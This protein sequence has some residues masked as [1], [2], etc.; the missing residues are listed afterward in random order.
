MK[1]IPHILCSTVQNVIAQV[2]W[3]LGFTHPWLK[4]SW[5]KLQTSRN[6]YSLLSHVQAIQSKQYDNT[7]IT[8]LENMS[9]VLEIYNIFLPRNCFQ[10]GDLSFCSTLRNFLFMD[11]LITLIS[12]CKLYKCTRTLVGNKVL[13]NPRI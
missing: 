12:A 3:C 9:K 2:T 7:H 8:A 13:Q 6:A 10:N 1:Q 5:N 4:A 11:T